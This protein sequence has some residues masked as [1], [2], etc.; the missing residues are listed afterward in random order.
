MQSLQGFKRLYV[1]FAL[2]SVI[3]Y[4]FS[5]IFRVLRIYFVVFLKQILYLFIVV[6]DL[7]HELTH[8]FR[9]QI[10]KLKNAYSGL[11]I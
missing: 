6:S 11:Q 5:T 10:P 3:K 9:L 7:L 8:P 2:L 1:A 4:R